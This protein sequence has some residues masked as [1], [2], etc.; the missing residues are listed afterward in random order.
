MADKRKQYSS[1]KDK[2]RILLV[3]DYPLMRKGLKL[4]INHEPDL[5]VCAQAN[6]ARQVS[7]T[8]EKGHVDVDLA[9]VDIS[10]VE[11][12]IQLAERIK[13][14]C[15]NLPVLVLSVSDEAIYLNHTLQPKAKKSVIS[16]QATEQITK[17]IHYIQTL[18]K[19]HI[20]GFTVLVKVERGTANNKEAGH[21]NSSILSGG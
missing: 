5:V 13:L 2:T 15:P 18:I 4:L 7:E 3:D 8:I 9:I 20:F 19:N 12:N 17:A 6:N 10:P 11:R 16:R 21:L 14:Q 1:N